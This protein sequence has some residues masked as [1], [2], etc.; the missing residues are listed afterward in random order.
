M[1][2]LEHKKDASDNLS[3]RKYLVC[4][5]DMFLSLFHISLH[6]FLSLYLKTIPPTL[7]VSLPTL[8]S[9]VFMSVPPVETLNPPA[10][11]PVQDFRYVY[12]HRPKVLT[13]EP[14]SANPSPVDSP[15]PSQSTSSSDLDI[16]IAFRKEK[17]LH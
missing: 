7:S 10:S 1:G 9:T 17:R 12:T 5:N 13:S 2:I 3:T 8:A 6:R 16:P 11:K 4:T 14:I 15:P